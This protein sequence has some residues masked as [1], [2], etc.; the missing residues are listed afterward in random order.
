MIEDR[1]HAWNFHDEASMKKSQRVLF[2]SLYFT[3]SETETILN[4]L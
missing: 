3:W 2:V 1:D 4:S